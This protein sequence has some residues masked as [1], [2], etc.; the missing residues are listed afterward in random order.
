MRNVPNAL[1]DLE[2]YRS[3]AKRSDTIHNF[4]GHM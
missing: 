4:P 2:E 3:D 1:H